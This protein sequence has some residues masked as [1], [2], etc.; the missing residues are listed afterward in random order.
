MLLFNLR[1]HLDCLTLALCQQKTLFALVFSLR[2][3]GLVLS[4]GDVILTCKRIANGVSDIIR[5]CAV[6]FGLAQLA[7]TTL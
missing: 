6:D 7:S 2:Q 3:V 5:I 4:L 1:K